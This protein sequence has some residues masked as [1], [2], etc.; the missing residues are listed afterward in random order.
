MNILVV[1]NPISGGRE[2]SRRVRSLV[3]TL[4]TRGH[5]VVLRW[6]RSA[7]D[8]ARL[9][10][11]ADTGLDRLVVAGGDGT[12]NEVMNGLRDPGKLVLAQ[13]PLGT[14]NLLGKEFG[15]PRAAP[16]LSTLIEQGPV[17]R[18]DLGSVGKRRFLAVAS[19]GFDAMVTEAI[20]RARTGRLGYRGWIA[21]ILR[22]LRHYRPPALRVRVDEQPEL[23]GGLFIASNVKTF[24]GLFSLPDQASPESGVLQ[25]CVFEGGR[26]TD[27]TRYAVSG[28]LGRVARLGDVVFTTGRRITIDS[29]EPVPLEVDGDSCGT[30]PAVI[31]LSPAIVPFVTGPAA[32]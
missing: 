17:R 1:A 23:R 3:E 18:L 12:L 22:T 24:G 7:G 32:P 30:T 28:L 5:A 6:T 25:V 26:I 2:G 21:P 8:A 11:E 4:E 14:A 9:A 16:E 19:C 13:L 29:D 15:L 31:E 20:G 10:R 27:L